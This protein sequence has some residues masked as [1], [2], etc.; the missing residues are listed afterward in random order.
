[1]AKKQATTSQLLTLISKL[2]DFDFQG[3]NLN[4]LPDTFESES[5]FSNHINKVL[6]KSKAQINSVHKAFENEK[7]MSQFEA[8]FAPLVDKFNG[9]IT[10]AFEFAKTQ[11]TGEIPAEF[12]S[13]NNSVPP[14]EIQESA[15]EFKPEIKQVNHSNMEYPSQRYTDNTDF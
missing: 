11:L 10:G 3:L 1:M 6:N 5:D 14:S 2:E 15:A 8:V 9:D 13:K 4:K 12:R 7:Y